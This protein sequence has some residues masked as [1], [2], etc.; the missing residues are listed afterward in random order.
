MELEKEKARREADI[1]KH[2]LRTC[3]DEEGMLLNRIRGL[4]QEIDSRHGK[5]KQVCTSRYALC[6]SCLRCL[7]TGSGGLQQEIDT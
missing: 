2:D 6:C 4:E 1:V 7:Q 3:L 5:D